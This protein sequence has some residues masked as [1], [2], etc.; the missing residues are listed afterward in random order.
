MTG[1]GPEGRLVPAFGAISGKDRVDTDAPTQS[2]DSGHGR[3][4]GACPGGGCGRSRRWQQQRQPGLGLHS[5]LDRL[6]DAKGAG[7]TLMAPLLSQWQPVYQSCP[8]PE[9]HLSLTER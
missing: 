8:S 9:T 1:Y 7:G 4:C 6:N 3:T 2:P 5:G